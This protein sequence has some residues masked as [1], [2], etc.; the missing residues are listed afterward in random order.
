MNDRQRVL[1]LDCGEASYSLGVARSLGQAGYEV[2]YGFPVGSPHREARSKYCAGVTFYPDPSYAPEDFQQS[3]RELA[4]SFRY[5]VPMKEQTLLSAAQIKPEV[6]SQ[7]ALLPIADFETLRTATTKLD[8]LRLA[9]SLG[10]RTPRTIVAQELPP[11]AELRSTLGVPFVMKVA[12]EI[13]L[14]P[15]D[16][17]YRVD[18]LDDSTLTSKFEALAAHGPVLLQEFARGTG[19]GVAL[20]Y[21]R[22][23]GLV[24]FSGHRRVFE[25]F[26]DGGPSLLAETFVDETALAQSRRLLEAIGWK[27]MA[28]V[29]YRLDPQGVPVFMEVNPRFWG[30]LSLAIASGVDFP[31]LLLRSWTTP[32]APVPIRPRRTRNFFSFEVLVT[33]AGSPPGKRPRLSALAL[34]LPRCLPG[35][36]VRELQGRDL[37]PSFEEFVHQLTARGTR[38]RIAQVSG[39]LLGPPVPYE[40]LRRLGVKTV[41]DLREPTETPHPLP[42]PPDGMRRI[43]FP[44]P[45]D[46]GLDPPRFSELVTLIDRAAGQGGVYV[47][48]R[49]GRGRAPMA[50]TGYLVSK[51]VP[52]EHAFDLV[53]D[54]RPYAT[55]QPSQRAAVYRLDQVLARRGG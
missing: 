46:T 1:V 23:R 51:R 21:S 47:H 43:E 41:V 30:T 31:T 54:H 28:M 13:G 15:M 14:R 27:G 20:L 50:V 53:Y 40:R 42:A 49:L 52:L 24:A 16:R 19:A 2:H 11:I 38:D 44:I 3:L 6:E 7:G 36:S 26:E 34:L 5:I 35:L 22:E 25:Q 32:T 55:L 17:H 8:M 4:P 12:S 10:V 18:T 48:C 37:R 29:E 45:D 33:A 9:E 39:V